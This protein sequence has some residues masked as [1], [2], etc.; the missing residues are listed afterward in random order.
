MSDYLLYDQLVKKYPKILGKVY[1]EM[2]DGW[3]NLLDTLCNSIQSYID[4]REQSHNRDQDHLEMVRA[5]KSGDDSLFSEWYKEKY[6]FSQD[7]FIELKREELLTN[8]LPTVMGKVEQVVATQVKEKLGG[9]RFYYDGGDEHIRGMISMAE[10]MSYS[11]CETC[12]DKGTLQRGGYLYT[13][14]PKHVLSQDI[15]EFT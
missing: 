14:C 3:Y 8:P 4:W 11:I 12:G 10:N 2:G 5:L 15:K 6:Y 1:P 9:L 13:A 7:N